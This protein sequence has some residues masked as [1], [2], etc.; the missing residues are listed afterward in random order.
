MA[1]YAIENVEGIGPVRGEQL[2]KAG[3]NDTDTLLAQCATPRQR[4]HL[5]EKSGL[6]DALILKFANLVDLYRVNGIGSEY[7]EL[8]EAAGVDTVPELA[9]RNPANLAEALGLVNQ[10]KQLVRRVPSETEVAKWVE[11]A[12]AL[13]RVLDY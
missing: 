1:N 7:S 5:A 3:I 11:Q 8:L 2:R 10:E 9:R 12:R 13:P 4:Q 6:S